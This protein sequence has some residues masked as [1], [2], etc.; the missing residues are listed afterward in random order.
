MAKKG[1]GSGYINRWLKK[2]DAAWLKN[3][4]A[5]Q[6]LYKKVEKSQNWQDPRSRQDPSSRSLRK[7]DPEGFND[8]EDRY[9][10]EQKGKRAES[11]Q[12][13]NDYWENE[14][15]FQDELNRSQYSMPTIMTPPDSVTM[16]TPR[17]QQAIAKNPDLRPPGI[18]DELRSLYKGLGDHSGYVN[19]GGYLSPAQE[20]AGYAQQAGLGPGVGIM[21]SAMDL[22]TAQY[23]MAARNQGQ[24][25]RYTPDSFH[26]PERM[27]QRNGLTGLGVGFDGA[28]GARGAFAGA[29]LNPGNPGLGATF[30]AM[31]AGSSSSYGLNAPSGSDAFH[32]NRMNDGGAS[33]WEQNESRI[34]MDARRGQDMAR[35]MGMSYPQSLNPVNRMYNKVINA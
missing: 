1:K 17:Y 24:A 33:S 3:Y 32:S 4:E 31:Q 5:Q 35:R 23:Q 16:N 19:Y 9:A 27:A 14:Q 29:G 21:P 11:Q 25:P 34:A 15:R 22:Q 6:D 2:N 28:A 20:Q 13:F 8:Y 12:E 18:R 7:N 26:S 10:T 30:G